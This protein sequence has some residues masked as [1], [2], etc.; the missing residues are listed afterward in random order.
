MLG[1]SPPV[2]LRDAP[3]VGQAVRSTRGQRIVTTTATM[4]SSSAIAGHEPGD[5]SNTWVRLMCSP[6][7]LLSHA[8][9]STN[10][11]ITTDQKIVF[12][13]TYTA[14]RYRRRSRRIWRTIN[15]TTTENAIASPS[16]DDL[17]G[18][19]E[20]GT[21]TPPNGTAISRRATPPNLGRRDRA[22]RARRRSSEPGAR[23]SLDARLSEAELR[24]RGQV[25][26]L[27]RGVRVRTERDAIPLH[28]DRRVGG[29][30]QI[31]NRGSRDG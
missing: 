19:I 18:S 2:R 23:L 16:S 29:L 5:C 22:A 14:S 24:L 31:G 27:E 8:A 28:D 20:S 4:K 13:V 26:V 1:A 3:G 15:R 30:V 6:P 25:I 7:R 9:R 11:P 12:V 10:A 21:L 17:P